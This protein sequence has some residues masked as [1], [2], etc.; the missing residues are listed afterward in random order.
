MNDTYIVRTF[1]DGSLNTLGP[2]DAQNAQK[3]CTNLQVLHGV[4]THYCVTQT[5]LAE[6]HPE[7][8]PRPLPYTI[9]V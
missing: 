3:I 7:C 6:L 4:P 2:F 1:P 5:Q 9:A 8:Y